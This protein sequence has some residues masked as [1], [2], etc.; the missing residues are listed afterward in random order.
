MKAGFVCSF[1]MSTYY[2]LK[3]VEK[4]AKA[5]GVE[6]SMDAI[7]VTELNDRIKEYDVVLLGPQ[8]KYKSSQVSAVAT[9]NGKKFVNIPPDVYGSMD[10]DRILN[11]ILESI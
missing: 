4:A 11:F 8:L 2:V 3:L 10:G 9:A 1:G 5:R 7:P 6:L